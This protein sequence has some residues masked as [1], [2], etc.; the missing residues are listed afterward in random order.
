[1]SGGSL[2]K[3]ILR[4]DVVSVVFQRKE[5]SLSSPSIFGL[6]HSLSSGQ[7]LRE[8]AEEDDDLMNKWGVNQLCHVSQSYWSKNQ[9]FAY[10]P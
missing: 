1:M 9:I 2:L 7:I 6:L 5:F 10:N 8:N 3:G 4:E